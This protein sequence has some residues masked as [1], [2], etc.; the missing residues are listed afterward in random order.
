MSDSEFASEVKDSLL[1][2]MVAA[3]I[4]TGAD[5]PAWASMSAEG[6]AKLLAESGLD[7]SQVTDPEVKRALQLAGKI[8]AGDNGAAQALVAHHRVEK[9]HEAYVLAGE[10]RSMAGK[11]MQDNAEFASEV[12]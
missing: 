11:T 9:R 10:L 3:G 7:A 4:V 8:A 6:A 12:K 1:S 2:A 5:D